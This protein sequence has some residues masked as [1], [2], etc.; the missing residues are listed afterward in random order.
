[1]T[2]RKNRQRHPAIG[3]YPVNLSEV[4]RLDFVFS[5][6]NIFYNRRNICITLVGNDAFRVVVQ[7]IFNRFNKALNIWYFFKT[8]L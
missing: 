5:L 8:E 6:H 3:D 2:T 1:M 4:V 7:L